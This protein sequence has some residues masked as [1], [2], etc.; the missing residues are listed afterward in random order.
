LRLYRYVRLIINCASSWTF[1]SIPLPENPTYTSND[2]TALIP[3]IYRKDQHNNFRLCLRS[4]LVIKPHEI[5]V[6]TIKS[7]LLRITELAHNINPR[8]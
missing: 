7:D 3:T 6:L 1:K 5:R 2:V 4:Y 8:I